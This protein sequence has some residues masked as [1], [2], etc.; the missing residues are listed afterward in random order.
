M[1]RPTT[2][3]MMAAAQGNPAPQAPLIPPGPTAPPPPT[4]LPGGQAYIPPG[5]NVHLPPRAL[6]Q[7]TAVEQMPPLPA[8]PLESPAPDVKAA[9]DHV[10]VAA[11][12]L[13]E[14]ENP[15]EGAVKI[16][17]ELV[18]YVTVR[19]DAGARTYILDQMIARG[20]VAEISGSLFI[21]PKGM[22]ILLDLGVM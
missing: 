2:A 3:A 9:V 1:N 7:A 5:T 19:P 17:R 6:T 10:S 16:I 21:T 11:E 4:P 22:G 20:L 12:E 8:R 18:Y 13:V 15:A 14:T